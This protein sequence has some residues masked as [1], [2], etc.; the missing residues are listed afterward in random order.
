MKNKCTS[1][2]K[3]YKNVYRKILEFHLWALLKYHYVGIVQSISCIFKKFHLLHRIINTNES[4]NICLLQSTD[5][6]A[7]IAVLREYLLQKKCYQ[8]L[9]TAVRY[10]RL[11]NR[12]WGSH[13]IY[14]IYTNIIRAY[15][16]SLLQRVIQHSFQ[17][18][19]ILNWGYI[20]QFVNR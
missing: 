15:I 8:I 2:A 13:T 7:N 12:A 16:F 19:Y 3:V 10:D 17:V 4:K 18:W 6:F 14:V 20:V 5:A 11:K 1:T 9:L